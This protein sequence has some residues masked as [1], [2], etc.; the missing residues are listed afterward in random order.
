MGVSGKY[1]SEFNRANIASCEDVHL[2]CAPKHVFFDVI[3]CKDDQV[4]LKSHWDSS[5]F[6]LKIK[7]DTHGDYASMKQKTDW[8]DMT[9]RNGKYYKIRPM[10]GERI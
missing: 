1:I 3:E 4:K 5:L 9:G 10:F 7:R 8:D 2:D 6:T